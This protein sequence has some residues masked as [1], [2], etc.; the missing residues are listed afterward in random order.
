MFGGGRKN[1]EPHMMEGAVIVM[2]GHASKWAGLCL[3][4]MMKTDSGWGSGFQS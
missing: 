1:D 3:A 4:T 2:T